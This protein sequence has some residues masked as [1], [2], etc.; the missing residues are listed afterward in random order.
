[1]ETV[2]TQVVVRSMRTTSPQALVNAYFTDERFKNVASAHDDHN[3]QRRQTPSLYLCFNI[4]IE[5]I[6]CVFKIR[7]AEFASKNGIREKI[8]VGKT[9]DDR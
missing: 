5:G 4:S 8:E 1:M 3:A 6:A 2:R 7:R 9:V